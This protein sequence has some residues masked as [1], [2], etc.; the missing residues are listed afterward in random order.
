MRKILLFWV[1]LVFYSCYN[2]KEQIPCPDCFTGPA[3]LN[4]VYL[5]KDDNNLL[6]PKHRYGIKINNVRTKSMVRINY[7]VTTKVGG[8]IE[9]GYWHLN[10]T[11]RKKRVGCHGS[12][13]CGLCIMEECEIYIYVSQLDSSY[14]DTLN[15][16][17]EKEIEYVENN[18]PCVYY[19]MRYVRHNNKIIDEFGEHSTWVIRK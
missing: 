4:I 7:E 8:T 13:D 15:V 10:L 2:E 14:V 1:A 9:T 16:L 18:C 3:P 11:D 5:D 12:L 6:A 17:Y 19:P